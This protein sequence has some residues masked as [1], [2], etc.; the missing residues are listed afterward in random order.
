[1]HDLK[2]LSGCLVAIA[3]LGFSAPAAAQAT[4][5]PEDVLDVATRERVMSDIDRMIRASFAHFAGL[6]GFDYDRA[7]NSYQSAARAAPDRHSFSLLT[8]AFVA[9]LNNGHTQFNDE[10]VYAADPGNLGFAVRYLEPDWVVLRSRRPDLPAGS[11]IASINGEPFE[12]FYTR[13]RVQLNASNDRIRREGLNTYAALFPRSFELT[14]ADG[15]RVQIDRSIPLPLPSA[16]EPMVSHRWLVKDQI[17]YIRIGRF[18]RPE[19]EAEARRVARGDYAGA[20]S[21]VI[22]VRGN[23]GGNTPSGLGRDLLGRDWTFW[24]L[25]PPKSAVLKPLRPRPQHP[26]NVVIVD[27]GC[28]SACDDFVMPFSLSAQAI[29]VGETSGGSSGQP[30]SKDWGNGMSLLVGARRQWFPDGR[31][32]EGVG[33]PVDVTLPPR[34]EDY[35]VGAPDRTLACASHIA[36]GGAADDAPCRS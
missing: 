7:W 20:K 8:E 13:V 29:L 25:T 36:G 30:K 1:M 32:F 21:V 23:G 3:M 19:Y 4:Q 6:P 9:S 18:N 15:R 5:R 12:A 34:R 16:A 24:K 10:A 31:E 27:R 26:R 22:D 28:G 14:L 2:S 11:V 17:A 35:V 33:V